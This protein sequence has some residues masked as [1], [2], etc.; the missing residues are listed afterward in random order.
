MRLRREQGVAVIIAVMSTTLMLTLGGALILLSSSETAIA[1]NFRSAHEAMYAA[2]A[3]IERALAD[4]RN[5][6]D[7][8]PVLSGSVQSSF[9]DGSPSGTRTLADGS[10]IDLDGITNLANC[11][12]ASVCSDAEV[13]AVTTE[14]PWGA[15]N[16]RWTLFA[17]GPLANAF[18]PAA[19]RSVFYVLA[20]VGDDPSENDGNPSVDG[21]MAATS[22]NPGNG[23]VMVRGEAFGPR[24]AHRVVEATIAR[25]TIPSADPGGQPSTELRVL[26]W[27]EVR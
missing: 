15:N 21:L 24:G 19:V 5:Q 25:L 23:I 13:A 9:A 3:A 8:T 22:P 18:R 2:D 17:Y 7:W 16:P 27:R 20:F 26:S 1:A 6:A 10:S 12:K 11:Q 14:R 4:L